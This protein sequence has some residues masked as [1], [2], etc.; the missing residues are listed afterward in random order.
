MITRCGFVDVLWDGNWWKCSKCKKEM[1][2]NYEKNVNKF[3]FETLMN[4]KKQAI[5]ERNGIK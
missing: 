2:I 1:D 4:R 5:D 3:E